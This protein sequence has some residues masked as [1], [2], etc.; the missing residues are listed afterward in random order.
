[1]CSSLY[2]IESPCQWSMES[3]G[4]NCIQGWKK[5]SQGFLKW[6]LPFVTLQMLNRSRVSHNMK[7]WIHLWPCVLISIFSIIKIIFRISITSSIATYFQPQRQLSIV[8]L[9]SLFTS[10]NLGSNC[11]YAHDIIT[12]AWLWSSAKAWCSA[13]YFCDTIM[14]RKMSSYLNAALNLDKIWLNF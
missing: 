3:L 12:W 5:K 4:W 8:V 9:K 2:R 6:D 1:M 14:I 10:G 7:C 11:A 13:G